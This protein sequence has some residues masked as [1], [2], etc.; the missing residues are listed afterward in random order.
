MPTPMTSARPLLRFLGIE[1]AVRRIA[2]ASAGMGNVMS[3][4]IELRYSFGCFVW[5]LEEVEGKVARIFSRAL[6]IPVTLIL[7]PSSPTHTIS[8]PTKTIG[9]AGRGFITTP[10]TVSLIYRRSSIPS[11]RTSGGN[12]VLTLGQSKGRYCPAESF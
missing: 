11:S 6:W 7:S 3:V 10:K 5:W 9:R 4:H 1:D 2:T 8:K 12:S